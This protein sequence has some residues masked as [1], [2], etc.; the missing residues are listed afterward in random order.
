MTYQEQLKKAIELKRAGLHEK[1]SSLLDELASA[2][3]YNENYNKQNLNVALYCIKAIKR[4][5]GAGVATFAA[6]K[7]REDRE[8]QLCFSLNECFFDIID[9]REVDD[10]KATSATSATLVNLI[11]SN[12]KLLKALVKNAS[13]QYVNRLLANN[14]DLSYLQGKGQK[15][16]NFFKS[17]S[18]LFFE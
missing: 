16:K 3:L 1:A 14:S 10:E 8:Q 2:I 9:F 12:K 7:I 11:K 5:R 17:N 15:L 18:S 4:R 13:A 6:M